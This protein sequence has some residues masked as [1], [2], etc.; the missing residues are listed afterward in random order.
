MAIP[1]PK[2]LTRESVALKAPSTLVMGPPGTGKTSSIATLL[3]AGI[4]CFVIATEGGSIP[5]LLDRC[6][7]LRIPTDKLHW[8]HVQPVA[9]TW[10]SLDDM[11]ANIT[12]STYEQLSNMKGIDKAHTNQIGLIPRALMNFKC[13]HC[14]KEFGDAADFGYDRALIIDGATGLNRL[15][16]FGTVGLKPTMAQGEWG[17]AMSLEEMFIMSLCNTLKC[18]FVLLAHVDREK[19]EVTGGTKVMVGLLG[20]KLAPKIPGDFSEVVLT[21]RDKNKYYWSNEAVDTDTKKCSLPHGSMLTPSF[22]PILDAFQKRL[23]QAGLATPAL[24]VVA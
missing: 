6:R 10:N 1:T 22:Q 13:E 24:T 23:D 9:A 14:K 20:N 16:R 12:T 21:V 11:V 8:I 15:C 3:A 18:Y 2:V 19:D 4:E 17:V 7:E 5:A